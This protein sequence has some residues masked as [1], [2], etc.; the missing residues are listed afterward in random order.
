MPK[1]SSFGP[2]ETQTFVSGFQMVRHSNAW[3]RPKSTIRNPDQSGFRMSTVIVFWPVKHT[4]STRSTTKV[5]C[6]S[7]CSEMVWL[8]YTQVL[9]LGAPPRPTPTPNSLGQALGYW[10][11]LLPLL[12]KQTI[13]LACLD[14]ERFFLFVKGSKG[15]S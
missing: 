4:I 3:D 14:L 8:C 11:K 5:E 9:S 7:K 12:E 13:C 2:F 15:T 10:S 1:R 6:S